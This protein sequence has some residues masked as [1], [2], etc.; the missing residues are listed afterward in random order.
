MEFNWSQ[1]DG[2]F[3]R[4]LAEFLDATLPSDW[5]EISKG[6]PGSE[7]Q[8]SFSREFAHELAERG[9]LTQNWPSAYGGADATPWRHI[10]LSEEMWSRAIPSAVLMSS[11]G[12]T[13]SSTS[14]SSYARR[15]GMR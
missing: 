2:E 10:I 7:A 13:S 8:A 15:A 14:P 5:D 3:R 4:E 1:E 11:P 6:G 12:W 9:W